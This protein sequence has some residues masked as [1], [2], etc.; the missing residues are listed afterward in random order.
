[1]IPAAVTVREGPPT[2][3]W[4]ALLLQYAGFPPGDPHSGKTYEDETSRRPP[5]IDSRVIRKE[6]ESVEKLIKRFRHRCQ[7]LKILK[8]YRRHQFFKS[9]RER[10]RDKLKRRRGRP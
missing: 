5:L 3:Q 2:L 4:A 1:M 10:I 8:E 9:R 6:G 7:K